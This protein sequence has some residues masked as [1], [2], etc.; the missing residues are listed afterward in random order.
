M[1]SRGSGPSPG[2]RLRIAREARGLS[3]EEVA[4]RLRLNAAL[5]L[6]LEEDRMALLGAPVFAKGHLRNYALLVGVS[7]DEIMASWEADEIPAPS[8]L[9]AL[10]LHPRRRSH[11][12]WGWPLAAVALALVL[13]AVF[14]WW[15]TADGQ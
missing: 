8:F 15:T 3:I 6:A 13:V 2:A 9:P 14:W 5:V 7:E 4:D 1:N 10:D 11:A 12:R